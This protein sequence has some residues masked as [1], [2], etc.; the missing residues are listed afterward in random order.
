MTPIF[1]STIS[2]AEYNEKEQTLTI[3]FRQGAQHKY[4]GVPPE[5][6]K[7]FFASGSKGVFFHQQIKNG[8]FDAPRAPK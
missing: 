8:G 4:Y 5:L 6:A 3:Q 2:A 1:S 7:D